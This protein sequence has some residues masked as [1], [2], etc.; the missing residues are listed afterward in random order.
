MRV[1]QSMVSSIAPSRRA[2]N[3]AILSIL[4]LSRGRRQ[5]RA[6]ATRVRRR[7]YEL[8][9]KTSGVEPDALEMRLV[10]G[11]HAVVHHCLGAVVVER[12]PIGL[13]DDARVLEDLLKVLHHHLALV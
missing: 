6:Q 8:S 2:R 7:P 9:P 11:V 5:D 12:Q 3:D 10:E 1:R 13:D 4:P